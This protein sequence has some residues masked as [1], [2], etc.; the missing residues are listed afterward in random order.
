VREFLTFFFK[1]ISDL[2]NYN[3]ININISL[4]SDFNY[5]FFFEINFGS[6]V[7]NRGLGFIKKPSYTVNFF[8]VKDIASNLVLDKLTD[9]LILTD[10][11]FM[12]FLLFKHEINTEFLFSFFPLLVIPSSFYDIHVFFFINKIVKKFAVL[13][14][15]VSY[16]SKAL[17]KF[18]NFSFLRPMQIFSLRK[19][20]PNAASFGNIAMNLI[21]K[22]NLKQVTHFRNMDCVFWGSHFDN[23]FASVSIPLLFFFEK[24]NY[25]FDDRGTFLYGMHLLNATFLYSEYQH[26]FSFLESNIFKFS[27]IGSWLTNKVG[28]FIYQILG[29]SKN[30]IA[31][32]LCLMQLFQL[33]SNQIYNVFNSNIYFRSSVNLALKSSYYKRNF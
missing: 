8:I 29:F 25:I 15:D 14:S 6:L 30:T 18:F 7:L 4:S 24:E 5:K 2:L 26:V 21:N 22:D 17:D 19:N 13:R 12:K 31:K 28:S 3:D 11:D 20:F 9:R 16:L 1:T 10:N 23:N 27:N 32:F 33:T